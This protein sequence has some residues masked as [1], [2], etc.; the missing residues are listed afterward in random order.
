[1]SRRYGSSSRSYDA[2]EFYPPYV[3]VSEKKERN[4]KALAAMRRKNAALQPVVIAGRTIAGSW[5]GKSWN[6]N[7]ERYADYSNRI[8]RGRSYVCQGAVLDLQI[9]G[10]C[11]KAQVQ[12]SRPK[13]YDVTVTIAKL[14]DNT[15]KKLRG[16]AMQCLNS[17]P[18]LLGG[19]FPQA[20][21]DVFFAE[22]TGLF[23]SPREIKFDC[24]CPDWASMCKH[25]AAVLYGIGNRLD[26][27][28]EML[29]TLRQVTVDELISQTVKATSRSLLERAGTVS[30]EDV[31]SDADLE[32]VFGIEMGEIESA[33]A[34]AASAAKPA[35]K[36]ATADSAPAR[37]GRAKRTP[38]RKSA[39]VAEPEPVASAK[40][41]KNK[42]KK[43][44]PKQPTPAARH[45]NKAP[46]AKK[47]PTA[48][49]A[50]AVKKA[51]A[52][53]KSAAAK[54]ASRTMAELKAALAALAKPSRAPG[55]GKA[56]AAAT[57]VADSATRAASKGGAAR[58]AGPQRG[59]MLDE[60][61]AAVPR[62]Q[63]FTVPDLVALLPAWTTLQV[64]NTVQRAAALGRLA[65]IARGTF[66][67]G[68]G[69]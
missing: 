11:V 36:P 64:A 48:N 65:K 66:R 27:A 22:K 47:V 29:F 56:S 9:E 59:A 19:S 8:G 39:P 13:P 63:P 26:Q 15:W 17:L 32:D 12:G 5:W 51:P 60:L 7:L 24:S 42:K 58:A 2:Y 23:P 16:E 21:K 45:A 54:S 31:L 46:A 68:S 62:N 33:P 43:T 38:Q 1:M 10:G 41:A 40:V 18:E 69:A 4:A 57:R 25:V 35:A 50:P 61:L 55:V 3:P 28:P 52:A 6:R 49:K 34:S 14:A 20:L 67:R 53:K 37:Q 30:G 44:P